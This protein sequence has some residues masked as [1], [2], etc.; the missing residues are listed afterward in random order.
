MNRGIPVI[1][2]RLIVFWYR[3]QSVSV[4]WGSVVSSSFKLLNG[5]RQGGIL[6]PRFFNVY[7]DDLSYKLSASNIGCIFSDRII[8]HI[9][10]ADDLIVFS[11]GVRLVRVYSP[12]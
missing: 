4:K 1:I 2:V 6:S 10:Y 5:V 12:L 3:F 7:I 9:A 8:N 11:P